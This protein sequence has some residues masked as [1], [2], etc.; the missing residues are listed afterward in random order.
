MKRSI[1]V[2]VLAIV[3]LTG[4]AVAG[5]GQGRGGRGGAPP[6]T[7]PVADMVNM[8]ITALNNQDAAYLMKVVAPDAVWADEDGHMIP[9][10]AWVNRLM[11][12]KPVKKITLTGLRG[13]AWDTGAWAAF[14]YTLEEP[15]AAGG[16]NTMKGTNSMT[17]KKTGDDWQV[18][19]VHAAVNGPAISA[20]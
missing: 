14:S 18:V 9:A 19:L 5:G 13:L 8:I 4:S 7:G 1:L 6:F 17:F 2:I 10:T 3:A 12:A 15:A 20:H 11:T 16:T